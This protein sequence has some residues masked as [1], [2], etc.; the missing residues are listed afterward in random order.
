M[1]ELFIGQPG[2]STLIEGPIWKFLNVHPANSL[3]HSLSGFASTFATAYLLRSSITAISSL[4]QSVKTVSAWTKDF[5]NLTG[6]VKRFVSSFVSNRKATQL[7][8]FVGSLTFLTRFLERSHFLS[9]LFSQNSKM[10]TVATGFLA[11]FFSFFFG[12]EGNA[13]IIMYLASRAIEVLVRR[14]VAK[15]WL[16]SFTYAQEVLFALAGGITLYAA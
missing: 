6:L 15:K 5:T 7:A 8:L 3:D 16:P 11:G 2:K 4:T 10:I 12:V 9:F 14:L 1:F 13:S